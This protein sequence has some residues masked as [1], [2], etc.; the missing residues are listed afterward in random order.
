V[1]IVR[2][3]GLF[4]RRGQHGSEHG[5]LPARRRPSPDRGG[6]LRELGGVLGCV[7]VLLVVPLAVGDPTFQGLA[8]YMICLTLAAFAVWIPLQ[9]LGV[10]SIAHAALM[11]VAAYAAALAAAGWGVGFWTQLLLACLLSGVAALLVASVAMRLT[12]LPAVA[13]VTLALGGLLVSVILNLPTYTG[14]TN[15][16]VLSAPLELFGQR[17]GV[18]DADVPLYLIGLA[19][20]AAVMVGSWLAWRSRW[21]TT[22]LAIKDNADLAESLGVHSYLQRVAVLGASG[23]LA[24]VSGILYAYY[25]RF[26]EPATFDANLSIVL[27]LAVLLG[28][29]ASLYGPLLGVAIYVFFPVVSPLDGEADLALYGVLLIVVA[30]FAPH[31]LAS[32]VHRRH[33]RQPPGP[34]VAAPATPAAEEMVRP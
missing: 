17:F 8:T 9:F 11:G 22:L 27:L 16:L 4:G 3:D 13:I 5:A 20:L 29:A 30:T 34:R 2:P 18:A 26:L 28:G 6:T 25:S 32:L 14:G 19:V 33:P 12:T 1:L 7:L 10:A 31:G 15:G 21:G 23:V 24:G